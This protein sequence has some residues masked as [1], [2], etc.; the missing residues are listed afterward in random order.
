MLDM[1]WD[2]PLILPS[3]VSENLPRKFILIH[4]TQS[5]KMSS[6]STVLI[7]YAKRLKTDYW[8]NFSFMKYNYQHSSNLTLPVIIA[9]RQIWVKSYNL[10]P[11]IVNAASS[12]G[13]FFPSNLTQTKKFCRMGWRMDTNH[14]REIFIPRFFPTGIYLLKVNNRNRTSCEICSKL[15]IKTPE[16]RRQIFRKMNMCVSGGKK[17]FF[18]KFD[19]VVLV[20]FLLT[21]NIFHTL[22]LYFYC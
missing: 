2:T 6:I 12:F 15:T 13:N 8:I 3:K 10:F 14:M 4:I 16:R 20:L 7:S 9:N 21:L 22:F 19:G 5:Q 18:G 11:V 17:Y 1:V